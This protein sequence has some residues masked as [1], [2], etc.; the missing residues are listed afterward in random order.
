MNSAREET[1][2]MEPGD[3]VRHL[4][5]RF[6]WRL[7]WRVGVVIKFQDGIWDR[8]YVVFS[9]GHGGWYRTKFLVKV[10]SPEEQ[11]ELKSRESYKEEDP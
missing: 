10:G 6:H 4:E 8:A 3:L 7:P 9:G 5:H 1:T 2:T 11:S